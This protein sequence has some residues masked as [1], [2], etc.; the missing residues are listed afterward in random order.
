MAPSH[1]FT[2]EHRPPAAIAVWHVVI[3]GFTQ[4]RGDPTGSQKLWLRLRG[5]VNNGRSCVEFF[6]WNSNWKDVAEWIWRC[7]P[8][9]RPPRVYVYAYSWGAGGGFVRLARALRKRGIEVERAVLSDP[10]YCPPLRCLAWTALLRWKKIHVP[11]NVRRVDY[12]FQRRNYPRGH[13]LVALD[14]KRT[15]IGRPQEAALEHHYM[16]GLFA[17]QFLCGDVAKEAQPAPAY[18]LRVPQQLEV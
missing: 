3:S 11:D 2:T 15:V 9:E 12:F 18:S 14:P 16:D 8:E 13:H 5:L 1:S 6:P 17:W 4:H 10:V 7:R